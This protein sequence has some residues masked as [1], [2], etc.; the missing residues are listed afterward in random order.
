[1]CARSRAASGGGIDYGAL[2]AQLMAQRDAKQEALHE[3]ECTVL[4]ELRRVT[5]PDPPLLLLLRLLL[6]LLL[7]LPLLL[8]ILLLLL[9]LH[10]EHPIS[11]LAAQSS[12]R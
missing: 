12:R 11:C 4:R 1:V 7:L 2:S 3:M 10:P 5:W 8:L 6:L 9:R